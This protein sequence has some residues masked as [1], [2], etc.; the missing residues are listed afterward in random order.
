MR[1]GIGLIAVVAGLGVV[2]DVAAQSRVVVPIIV[3]RPSGLAPGPSGL[4]Q[5]RVIIQNNRGAAPA[6]SAPSNAA[7]P[8]VAAPATGSREIRILT[9]PQ[10]SQ[11]TRVFVHEQTS[12]TGPT[13]PPRVLP[14]ASREIR[15]FVED[16]TSSPGDS[17]APRVLPRDSQ[18]IRVFVDGDAVETPIVI[19]PE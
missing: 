6:S 1:I 18:V 7:G 15:V 17:R 12:G 19:L 9:A 5:T 13:E 4:S 10:P 14:R 3:P 16:Q 11:G 8:S 2:G